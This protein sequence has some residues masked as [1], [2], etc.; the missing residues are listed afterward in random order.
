MA[1]IKALTFREKQTT[2]EDVFKQYK[3][4][5][6]KLYCLEETQYYPQLYYGVARDQV[7]KYKSASMISKLN[8]NLE[9]KE[10][11]QNVI[12]TFE[13]IIEN[14]SV[15]SK[16]IIVKEFM[17]NQDSDWWYNYYAKST[18]YRMKTKAMEEMLFYLNI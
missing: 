2:L 6:I 9:T 17:E 13:C 3:R 10:E 5:K 12:S 4:A 8:S 15:D 7:R 1:K 18:Y 11:L 16:Q 14:L